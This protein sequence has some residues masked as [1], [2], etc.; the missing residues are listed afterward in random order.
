MFARRAAA[1]AA[2]STRSQRYL[3]DELGVPRDR[4]HVLPNFRDAEPHLRLDGAD[5]AQ[6]RATLGWP[7]ERPVALYLG[8]LSA[9]KRPDLAVE[10]ASLLP[11]IQVVLAG[12]GQLPPAVAQAAAR[13]GVLVTGAVADPELALAAADTILLTSQTEGLPGVLIEAGLAA[14]PAASTACRLR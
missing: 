6:L 2:I 11:D 1:V 8:A 14:R 13:A 12:P 5:R 4:V 3:V 7:T 9:E 10:V